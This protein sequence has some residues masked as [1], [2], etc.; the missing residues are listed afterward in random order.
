[1]DT[2]YKDNW[3][4]AIFAHRGGGRGRSFRLVWRQG[5][6]ACARCP[7]ASWSIPC[8][9]GRAISPGS[10]GNSASFGLL[11]ALGMGGQWS[12]GVALVMETWPEHK[13][14][15]L[16]G[17]IGAAANLG[18]GLIGAVAYFF[19]V[20]QASWRWIMLVGAAPAHLHAIFVS[21]CML[22]P[23]STARWESAAVQNKAARP[24]REDLCLP[25]EA[26]DPDRR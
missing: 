15:W 8:S 7:S 19:P 4:T 12:L 17:A 6:G 1:M 22:L 5:S 21:A 9:P 10:P 14:A 11:A 2:L 23:E 13:R 3:L 16:A 25:A 26:P 20:T 24:F 18:I